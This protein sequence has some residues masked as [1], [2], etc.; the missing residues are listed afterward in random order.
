MPAFSIFAVYWKKVTMMMM[1]MSPTTIRLRSE[2]W[3]GDTVQSQYSHSE[4]IFHFSLL[5]VTT[6]K[7]QTVYQNTFFRPG[8]AGEAY[9]ALPDP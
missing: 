7:S 2:H 5:T 6:K 4:Y 3:R 9:I 8:S 1:M